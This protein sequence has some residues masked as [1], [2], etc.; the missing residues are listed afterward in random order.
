M[1][2]LPNMGLTKW[3]Q[4][5][6]NFS[7]AQLAANFQALDDHDHTPGNGVQIPA[8]GLAPLSVAAANLQDEVFTAEKIASG[9][10][11]ADKIAANAITSGQIA[12][13]TITDSDLASPNNGVW[14]TIYRV[15]HTLKSSIAAGTYILY[16][17][18]NSPGTDYSGVALPVLNYIAA[19]DT[20]S[21]KTTNAR[22][23]AWV[24]ANGVNPGITTMT[25][26]LQSFAS[27][28]TSGT[29]TVSSPG[30]VLMFTTITNALAST[31]TTSTAL[32]NT[33]PN[34]PAVASVTT[35]GSL[36]ANSVAMVGV[37]IQVNYQ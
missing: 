11:T 13:G 10:I 36:S 24:S 18:V 34:G 33:L 25:F 9:S 6:D 16:N 8:G 21:G 23:R 29:Y 2:T 35:S 28:G 4:I 20:V 3:D 5:N 17:G 12:N 32:P 27:G 19:D 14:K 15:S 7:H 31:F 1:I 30:G 22:I 37:D 26:R